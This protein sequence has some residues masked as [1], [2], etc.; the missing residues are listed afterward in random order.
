MP[1]SLDTVGIRSMATFRGTARRNQA[2]A[3]ENHLTPDCHCPGE[4]FF[5]MPVSNPGT[6]YPS[7]TL[8]SIWAFR[9]DTL[10]PISSVKIWSKD[11]HLPFIYLCTFSLEF[12][13]FKYVFYCDMKNCALSETIQLLEFNRVSKASL[14]QWSL[15]DSKVPWLRMEDIFF[16]SIHE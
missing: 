14:G 5:D 11:H 1:K 15:A 10:F 4:L 3:G 13:P 2:V 7:Y 6:W 8:L 16:Y 9:E 12:L